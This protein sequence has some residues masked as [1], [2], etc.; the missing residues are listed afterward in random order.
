M[1]DFQ[2]G[3][4]S[5]TTPLAGTAGMFGEEELGKK[6]AAFERALRSGVG[7]EVREQLAREL[8]DAA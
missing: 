5:L 4:F 8:L 1:P 3:T 2:S 7:D 6:A